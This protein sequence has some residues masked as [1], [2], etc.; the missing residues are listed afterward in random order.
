[1]NIIDIA[2]ILIIVIIAVVSAKKG[3]LMSLFNIAAFVAS[4]IL[5][6]LFS[7]P[8]TSFIY[9]NYL[10]EKVLL[11]LNELLP[12]G[13]V[14]GEITGIIDGVMNSLPS[15]LAG[16]AKQFGIYNIADFEQFSQSGEALTVEMLEREYV[17]PLVSNI[18]S[19]IVIVLLFIL[20]SFLLKIVLSF[21]NRML[22]KKK[23]KIIRS[24]NMFLGAALGVIKGVIPAG[25]VCALLNIIAPAFNNETLLELTNNSYFCNLIADILK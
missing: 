21:I 12:S 15:F 7:S 16:V 2:V 23:H 4:G 22:T 24:T 20:F 1:M 5:A 18:V 14:N 11:K 13:S 17:G 25:L 19:V 3:F 10:S 9:S 6:R 8:V